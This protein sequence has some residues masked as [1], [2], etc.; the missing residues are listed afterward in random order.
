LFTNKDKR[1]IESP[2]IYYY[3]KINPQ[4]KGE[5][6]ISLADGSSFLSEYRVNHGKVL[7]LNTAPVLNWSNLPLKNI[8]APLI[9][10]LIYYL[11]S[12]D[13]PQNEYYAG[14]SVLVDLKNNTFPQIKIERPDKSEDFIN[15][16]DKPNSSYYEYNKTETAGN[17]KVY[18]G[19]NIL[20]GF[21]VNVDPHESVIKYIS[22][23]E[24]EDYLKKIN[25]KGKYI[26]VEKDEN[27]A[28]IILQSRF[29]SELWRYFLVFAII[30]A[31][32]E[33]TVARNAKKEMVKL[34]S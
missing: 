5:N 24:F 7:L 14:S 28:K 8:F 1:N 31:F 34:N 18:S 23:G 11:A 4:S 15:L 33:M 21:S 3:F 19:T 2:D 26:D 25:F 10:R 20:T 17:Y 13:Q 6:I 16:Q 12:K 22:S 29:G 30:L 32:A 9:N 27:P